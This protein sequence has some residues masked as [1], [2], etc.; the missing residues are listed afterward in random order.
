[1][2]TTTQSPVS[3]TGLF[4]V[5]LYALACIGFNLISAD[6]W[7]PILDS[8]NL[9]LHE[10]GHPL[11]SIFSERATVYGGT[12]FQ[13][14]FPIA[15]AWH[16]YRLEQLNGVGICL[17]WLAENTF[18]I[19]RYMA[20]AR[21]QI[22]PLVGNGEHDWTEIFSR[23]GVLQSDTTIAGIVRSIGLIIIFGTIV[24]MLKRWRQA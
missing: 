10:A 6:A 15:T 2:N 17:I 9:A 12:L 13:L 20:D 23:W 4:L 1:M 7:F 14:A 19:A 3:S 11:V 24:W 16:F 18:N 8:A 22:L 5:V 21:E